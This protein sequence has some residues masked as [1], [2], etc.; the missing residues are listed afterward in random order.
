MYGEHGE[1]K[2]TQ[3]NKHDYLG[4]ILI[5]ENCEVKV[6]MTNYVKDVLEVFPVKFIRGNNIGHLPMFPLLS[7]K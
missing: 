2:V 1:V 6:D 3:G 4:M 5:F 7:L